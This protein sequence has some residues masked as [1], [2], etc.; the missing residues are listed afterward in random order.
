ML[1]AIAVLSLLQTPA[2]LDA[3]RYEL[4]ERL[5]VLDVA[6]MQTT[7]R[8]RRT[9]AVPHITR[10]VNAFFTRK[11]AEAAQAL[12]AANSALQGSEAPPEA[13][14]SVRFVPAIC[15]PGKEAKLRIWWTY[16]RADARPVTIRVAGR[17]VVC[18]PGRTLNIYINP[19]KL[20]SELAMMSEGGTAIPIRV[21]NLQRTAYL[22]VVKNARGRLQALADAKNPAAKSLVELA[23]ESLAKPDSMEQDV[24]VTQLLYLAERL[25]DG[26]TKLWEVRDLARI[27]YKDTYFRA[28]FPNNAR[29]EPGSSKP[30]NVVIAYHGAGGSENLFFE[31]YGRGAAA[32][33]AI[34]RG[35]VFVAPR[36]GTNAQKDVLEWLTAVRRLKVGKVFLMG[37]SMGGGYTLANMVQAHPAAVA[38]FA[39]V[40]SVKKED[41]TFP[42][43][44]GVGKQEIG[45]LQNSVGQIAR[46]LNGV[47]GFTYQQF[48]PCE[49]LMVVAEGLKSAYA[50]FDKAAGVGPA[51]ERK[52]P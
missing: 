36:M 23:N 40:G 50:V 9:A 16:Q 11:T 10:A 7:D 38:L 51:L 39:P 14:I 44:L 27:K 46:D 48:D 13:G 43:F 22:N 37:H 42:L 34:N 41:V 45:L 8:N 20:D 2:K 17:S 1:A 30:V 35:W 18:A 25:E 33:Q 29:V 6:W 24:P 19:Q 5:K 21:G 49:H 52:A 26:E 15:E 3:S 47:E 12:D 32:E 4:G 31:G 28:S